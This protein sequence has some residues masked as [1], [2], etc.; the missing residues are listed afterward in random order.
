MTSF[1]GAVLLVGAVIALI[2][3]LG[4]FPR[5]WQALRASRNAFEIIKDPELADDRKESLLQCYSLSAL[6]S[7]LDLLIRGAGA[8]VIPVALLWGLDFAGAVSLRAVLNLTASWPFL[9]GGTLAGVAA[10]WL[11]E[12]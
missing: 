6:S 1:L 10:L 4:L 9:L 8:I 11:L 3:V 5:G 2:R 7:F 12:K